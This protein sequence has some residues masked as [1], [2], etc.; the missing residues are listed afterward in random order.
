MEMSPEQKA[1]IQG[2]ITPNERNELLQ[3]REI[4][5]P[6]KKNEREPANASAS[7]TNPQSKPIKR[8]VRHRSNAPERSAASE[9]LDQMLVPVTVRLPH[10]L[11]N[12]L[13]RAQLEQRLKH[14]KPD[15]QQ[16]IVE[17]ALGAW[18]TANDFR[19]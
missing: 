15:T 5:R 19:D 16:E 14:A 7:E 8:Q 2:G 6:Q 12:S 13:R 1:F 9:V 3:T 17:Q 11:A 18:L 4:A 10:K